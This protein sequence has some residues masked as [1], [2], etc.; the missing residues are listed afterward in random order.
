M[1]TCHTFLSLCFIT[2]HCSLTRIVKDY[3]VHLGLSL[4]I[5]VVGVVVVGGGGGVVVVVVVIV[6]AVV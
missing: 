1:L 6:V 2:Q 4:L 3:F 5:L